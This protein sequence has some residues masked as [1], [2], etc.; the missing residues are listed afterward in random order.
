M[1]AVHAV[2]RVKNGQANRLVEAFNQRQSGPF[3]DRD[4][5]A[6]PECG[7]THLVARR[8][9]VLRIVKRDF[10]TMRRYWGKTAY[11]DVFVQCDTCGLIGAAPIS[12]SI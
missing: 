2:K 11:S 12:P 4:Q 7:S 1:A 5:A 9:Y 6:C 10:S 8:E 3:A